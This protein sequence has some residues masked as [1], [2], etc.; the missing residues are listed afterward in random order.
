VSTPAVP[1]CPSQG[2]QSTCRQPVPSSGT[3][4]LYPA[5]TCFEMSPPTTTTMSAWC[6]RVAGIAESLVA[7]GVTTADDDKPRSSAMAVPVALS[8]GLTTNTDVVVFV[9]SRA[10]FGASVS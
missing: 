2:D 10:L 5:G 9:S 6:N 7:L 4:P 8:A 1:G 3:H